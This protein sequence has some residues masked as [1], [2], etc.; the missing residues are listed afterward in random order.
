[1]RLT[2]KLIFDCNSTNLLPGGLR[3]NMRHACIVDKS[4]DK[5]TFNSACSQFNVE[6][7]G[8]GLKIKRPEV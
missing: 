4:R 2:W 7:Q 6:V 5:Y 8:V 1:M 3:D